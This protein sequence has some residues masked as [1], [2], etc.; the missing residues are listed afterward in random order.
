[1][2]ARPAKL[3]VYRTAIPMR[4]FEHAAAARN[5]AEAVVVKVFLRWIADKDA[6]VEHIW[7]SVFVCVRRRVF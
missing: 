2:N 1:M 7:N 3:D 4:G 6:A 5:I